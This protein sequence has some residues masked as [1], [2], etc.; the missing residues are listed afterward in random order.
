MTRMIKAEKP[1]WA[2]NLIHQIDKEGSIKT[3]R[4][5]YTQIHRDYGVPAIVGAFGYGKNVQVNLRQL[6]SKAQYPDEK[7]GI[8]VI[9]EVA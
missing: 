7:A 4:N 1:K 3:F 6:A 2:L 5:S 9:L 8:V